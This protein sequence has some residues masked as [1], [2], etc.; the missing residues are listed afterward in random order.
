MIIIIIIL[1][2]SFY[3]ISPQGIVNIKNN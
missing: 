2:L 1:F 3:L